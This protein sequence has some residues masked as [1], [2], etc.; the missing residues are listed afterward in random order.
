MLDAYRVNPN[1][2][3]TELGGM[4][5]V[6]RQTVYNYLEDLKKTG[7]VHVNGNGVEVLG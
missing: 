6:T 3:A 2:G 4:I 5:G 7:R 1:V